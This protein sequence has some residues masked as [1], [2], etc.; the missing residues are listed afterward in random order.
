MTC[1]AGGLGVGV[2]V[3]G[4]GG[5]GGRVGRGVGRTVGRSVGEAVGGTGDGVAARAETAVL[6]SPGSL[7]VNTASRDIAKTARGV[8]WSHQRFLS[9]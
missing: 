6:V 2:I 9:R 1:I 7:C 5:V 8:T 4:G 3:G